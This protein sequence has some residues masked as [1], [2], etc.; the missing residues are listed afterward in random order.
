[1][2]AAMG[3]PANLREAVRQLP[4]VA[5]ELRRAVAQAQPAWEGTPDDLNGFQLF[6]AAHDGSRPLGWVLS[7]NQAWFGADYIPYTL[8]EVD[9]ALCP[10][11]AAGEVKPATFD[12]AAA[13][14]ILDEQR[15]STDTFGGGRFVGGY[16]EL[17]TVDVRGVRKE[18]VVD[19][20][21]R[22]GERIAA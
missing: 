6:V 13:R 7:T 4:E 16:G 14:A 20:P 15:T 21:D 11:I 18:R 2:A 22:V 3:T 17:T 9:Q 19:W 8:A 12:L 1:M 10:P 5:R